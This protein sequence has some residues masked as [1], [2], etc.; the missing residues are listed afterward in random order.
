MATRARTPARQQA[1]LLV[2]L[3]AKPGKHSAVQSYCVAPESL[4]LLCKID[5]HSILFAS[6]V[7]AVFRA[8]P[9]RIFLA[10]PIVCVCIT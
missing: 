9:S 3:R 8:V 7:F 1:T 4:L 6:Q 10:V 2:L 5:S